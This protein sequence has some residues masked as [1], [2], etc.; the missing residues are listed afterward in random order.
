MSNEAKFKA[1]L[2]HLHTLSLSYKLVE[3]KALIWM[4][5]GL[6]L[7]KGQAMQRGKE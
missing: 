7:C 6:R 5:R 1:P 2:S 3:T 4:P